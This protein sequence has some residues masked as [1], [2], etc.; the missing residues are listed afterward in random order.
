MC[1]CSVDLDVIAINRMLCHY[2]VDYEVADSLCAW[3]GLFVYVYVLHIF[4]VGMC[5]LCCLTYAFLTIVSSYFL[6]WFLPRILTS[7]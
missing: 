5:C 3:S 6:C 2:D 4:Q 7:Y 1:I